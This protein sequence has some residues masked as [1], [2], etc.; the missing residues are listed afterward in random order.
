M[1][2]QFTHDP[3]VEQFAAAFHLSEGQYY[4]LCKWTNTQELT[5]LLELLKVQNPRSS[6]RAWAQKRVREWLDSGVQARP[7]LMSHQYLAL[8]PKWPVRWRFPN[9]TH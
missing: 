8:A 2:R 7:P 6:D 1:D 3:V 9:S 4:R 5:T